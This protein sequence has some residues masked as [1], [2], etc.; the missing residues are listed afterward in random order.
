MGVVA[1]ESWLFGIM[2][3]PLYFSIALLCGMAIRRSI[4]AVVV[5]P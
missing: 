2:V 4:T 1:I 3:I 5:S